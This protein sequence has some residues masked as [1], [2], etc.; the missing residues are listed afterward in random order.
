MSGKFNP[1]AFARTSLSE[2]MRDP[3]D[4]LTSTLAPSEPATGT[5][6]VAPTPRTPRRD[7]IPATPKQ[8]AN[9]N[10][11]RLRAARASTPKKVQ[12]NMRLDPVVY[13]RAIEAATRVAGDYSLGDI[14]A[15]V[16]DQFEAAAERLATQ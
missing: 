3:L 4:P 11:S 2:T 12:L 16:I 9:K 10:T 6:P 15:Q 5:A 8:A 7:Q 1:S 13:E 14:F